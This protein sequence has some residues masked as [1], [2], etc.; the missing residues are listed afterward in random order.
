MDIVNPTTATLVVLIAGAG[1]YYVYLNVVEPQNQ[2]QRVILAEQAKREL[3]D[4]HESQ[5]R[6]GSNKQAKKK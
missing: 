6:R 4:E 1:A 2:L 5:S 3:L